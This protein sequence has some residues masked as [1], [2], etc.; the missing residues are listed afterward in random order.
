MILRAPRFEIRIRNAGFWNSL[1]QIG[2]KR[3]DQLLGMRVGQRLKQN[4]IHHAENC[5][6]GADAQRQR[7]YRDGS[8]A[9]VFAQH[10]KCIARVLQK[11]LEPGRAAQFAVGLAQLR[12]PS[13]PDAR[14]APRLLRRHPPPNIFFG[15][16]LEMAGQFALEILLGLRRPG[17]RRKPSAN[18]Q[19]DISWPAS[20][21]RHHRITR[22]PRDSKRAR[23]PRKSAPNSV[24]AYR[25]VSARLW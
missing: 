11:C 4:R 10:A 25:A 12:S 15:E 6:V 14:R 1:L 8:E 20:R 21:R 7:Q 18:P 2:L 9:G 23:S 13:Q 16:H 24:P 22:A 17:T 3:G 5:G 19:H